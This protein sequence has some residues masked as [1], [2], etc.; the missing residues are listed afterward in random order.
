MPQSKKEL[1][2]PHIHLEIGEE[3]LKIVASS[4]IKLAD[5][6]TKMN[7]SGLTQRAIVLLLHDATGVN[8][9]EIIKAQLEIE[10]CSPGKYYP[11]NDRTW[12]FVEEKT[13][14]KR[15]N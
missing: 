1:R 6:L 9:K 8:K 11:F 12:Q 14:R 13:G 2:H 4:V 3:P 10:R 5:G 15:Q 7:D